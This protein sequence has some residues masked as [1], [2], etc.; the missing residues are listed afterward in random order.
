MIVFFSL[1]SFLLTALRDN[2]VRSSFLGSYLL[3]NR[4]RTLLLIM[5]AAESLGV[6]VGL[7]PCNRTSVM[8]NRA[9]HAP[10]DTPPCSALSTDFFV[11]HENLYKFVT[12]FYDTFTSTMAPFRS[13]GS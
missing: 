3:L 6:M 9:T 1:D 7:T 11:V 10:D 8:E 4:L 2:F 13:F 12:N 5:S